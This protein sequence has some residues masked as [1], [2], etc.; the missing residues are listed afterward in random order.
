MKTG[1]LVFIA[2]VAGLTMFFASCSETLT[3]AEDLITTSNAEKSSGALAYPGD[4]CTYSGILNDEEK[5]GLMDMREEEKLARDV[6]IYFYEMY[7]HLIFN[8]IS[9]AEEAHTSAVSRLINGYGLE[10]P[11]STEVGKFNNPIYQYLYDSLTVAGSI[12]LTEALKT[13]AFIEEFDINDLNQLLVDTQNEDVYRVY[14]NL[15]QGYKNHL[16]AFTSVLIRIDETYEPVIISE[17]EY[18]EIL[19]DDGSS[20]ENSA[21]VNSNYPGTGDCDGTGPRF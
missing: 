11:A 20:E 5:E 6:Y 17:Q 7:D 19:N 12:S 9:K 13:G 21:D 15:L 8:N 2:S 3:H 16:R 4:S 18:N 14:S 10:D 1:K